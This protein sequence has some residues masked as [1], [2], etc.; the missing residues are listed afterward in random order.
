MESSVEPW[1]NLRE[2][3][4]HQR[5]FSKH[6]AMYIRDALLLDSFLLYRIITVYPCTYGQSIAPL[7]SCVWPA[8]LGLTSGRTLSPASVLWPAMG[9][10]VLLCWVYPRGAVAV[11]WPADNDGSVVPGCVED[12]PFMESWIGIWLKSSGYFLHSQCCGN[13]PVMLSTSQ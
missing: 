12:V 5:S 13:L 4:E 9:T 6:T 8:P 2:P 7:H 3:Q 11:V 10:P 1:W